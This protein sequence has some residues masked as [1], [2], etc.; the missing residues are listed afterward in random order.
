MEI[1]EVFEELLYMKL[2]NR[3]LLVLIKV[4]QHKVFLQSQASQ[5]DKGAK[6]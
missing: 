2:G 6:Y 1:F 4:Y 3:K 5:G